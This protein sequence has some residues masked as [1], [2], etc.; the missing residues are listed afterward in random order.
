MQFVRIL[1]FTA[2]VAAELVRGIGLVAAG[3]LTYY[4]AFVTK[5]K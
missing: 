3:A 5:V 1:G 2:L 4:L